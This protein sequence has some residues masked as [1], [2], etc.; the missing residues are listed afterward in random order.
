MRIGARFFAL[1]F[2]LAFAGCG[3]FPEVKDETAGWTAERL[4]QAGK[5]ALS[6]GNYTRAIKMFE[7]LEGRFP[8]G[9][10]AQQAILE[11]AYANYKSAEFAA[12]VAGADRFIKTYPNHPNVDYAYYLKGLANFNDDLGLIGWV[13]TQDLSERDPKAA[14][15]AYNTYKELVAKFPQ[16]RYARDS[17]ARLNYLVNALSSHEVHVSRYYFNRGAFVAAANRAQASLVTYPRTPANE[18]ALEVLVLSYDRLGLDKLR[19]DSRKI[20]A[21]TF[22]SNPMVTGPLTERPW[23]QFWGASPGVPAS[24]TAPPADAGTG[25]P[26]KRPWWKFW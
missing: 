3:L 24:L 16:S 1:L 9:R 13:V 5:E 10:H 2:A 25:A 14:R 21:A 7:T 11:T 12:A 6:E 17:V 18:Q 26:E 23:W 15:E 8:Y 20:L 22:P 4:Y 19:D